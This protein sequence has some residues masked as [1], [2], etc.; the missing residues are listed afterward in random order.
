MWKE[1]TIRL[2][3]FCDGDYEKKL[4]IEI[5]DYEEDGRNRLVAETEEI[6]LEEL[7]E[8]SQGLRGNADKSDE[9]KLL[10]LLGIKN[11]KIPDNDK[12]PHGILI[13]N[14]ALVS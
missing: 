8:K 4:K 14:K 1:A 5:W 11:D 6:T 3:Q 2:E 12:I 7:I 10:K 9:T 13:A